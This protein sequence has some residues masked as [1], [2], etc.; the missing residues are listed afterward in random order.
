MLFSVLSFTKF[1]LLLEVMKVEISRV[2]G[3]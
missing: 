1:G 2:F 3:K